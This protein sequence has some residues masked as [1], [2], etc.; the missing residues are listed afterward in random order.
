M[1]SQPAVFESDGAAGQVQF[2]GSPG[3]LIH[4]LEA[5]I[6]TRVQAPHP[7][8]AGEGVVPSKILDIQNLKTNA[9]RSS[10]HLV[11]VQ[12]L[13]A[14]ENVARKEH[15]LRV[16]LHRS[17]P[18][19]PVIQK[20]SIRRQQAVY[21]LK[22]RFKLR[23]ADVLEHP[24]GRD[25]VELA[26]HVAVIH[27][28]D[29]HRRRQPLLPHPLRRVLRLPVAQR[30]SAG[31]GAETLGGVDDQRS[32][33]A[34]DIE[35]AVSI[36]HAKLPADVVELGKLGLIERIL[37]WRPARPLRNTRFLE[38]RTGVHHARIQKLAVELIGT[39]VMEAYVARGRLAS[40]PALRQ[41]PRCPAADGIEQL[42]A[43]SRAGVGQLIANRFD[44]IALNVK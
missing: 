9:L 33:S 24:D 35:K 11:N 29:R 25:L 32:P 1:Q 4:R 37:P 30:A 27:F 28:A 13:K 44:Q 39:V 38:I 26:G 7:R 42:P 36:L 8:A 43:P 20:Q 17:G 21:F 10:N 6:A 19:D 18:R 23:P 12:D 15:A 41:P 3:F 5:G 2:P 14:R 34:T 40:G 22:I 16:A 31:G